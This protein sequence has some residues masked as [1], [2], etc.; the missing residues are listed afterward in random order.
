MHAHMHAH[1]I[2]SVIN[3]GHDVN[4]MLNGTHPHSNSGLFYFVCVFF[5]KCVLHLPT[6][7]EEKGRR[8]VK[9]MK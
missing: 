5:L 4:R 1:T 7:Q 9:I 3:S 2:F 8:A 6:G